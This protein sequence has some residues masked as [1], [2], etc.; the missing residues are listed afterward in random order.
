M[1]SDTT[2]RTAPRFRAYGREMRALTRRLAGLRAPATL[3][4]RRDRVA[5]FMDAVARDLGTLAGA[6]AR[7][8]QP[9]AG[10]AVQNAAGH[11]QGLTKSQG[12]L[13]REL[14]LSSRG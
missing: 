4:G 11:S 5:A 2:P 1:P 7:D 12:E 14:Q 8:D 10:T 9:A 3:D 13:A 6:A